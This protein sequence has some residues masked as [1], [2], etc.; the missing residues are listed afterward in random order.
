MRRL[1]E[2]KITALH[3]AGGTV[4][5]KLI[6]ERILPKFSLRAAG[7]IGLDQL[8]DGAVVDLP[9]GK[10]VVTTDSHVVKPI[11]FPGGDIGKLSVTG[12]VNDLV[13]MGAA[14]VAITLALVVEEG[15]PI[16]DL[17]RILASAAAVLEEVGIPLVTGD[18]KVMGK[19]EVDGIVINTTGIGVAAEPI[20]ASGLQVGDFILVTGPVGDHGMAVL[21]ARNALPV[22]VPV[23]SDVA[24]LWPALGEAIR[25]GGITAMKDPTRGGL[26][27]ALNEMAKKSG[28]G[29]AVDEEKIPVRPEVRAMCEVLGLS[30]YE[31]ACEGR[32]VLGVR[33][34]K[35]AALLTA[36][37]SHPL[38]KDSQV[39][40]QATPNY[41]GKV[42]LHTAVGGRRFLEMPIG[43]PL[44]RV[45]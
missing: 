18:T 44:P 19:G 31:L 26:A 37:R 4:M 34:D 17:E 35:L 38:T 13:V 36:L 2:E 20:P 3:G 16:S 6:S 15:F 43:D 27:A 32:A 11:F 12:T 41:P 23:E 30:P 7:P 10:L 42:V 1:T 25:R 24:P 45:C 9:P 33:P 40:G 29:I 22:E 8:D 39:I 5:E 14:P 21:C 28:V